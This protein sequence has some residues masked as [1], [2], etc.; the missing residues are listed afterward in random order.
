MLRVTIELIDAHD[1]KVTELA[2][3]N[4]ENIGENTVC[5]YRV[6]GHDLGRP[7]D[8]LTFN[9]L[10]SDGWGKLLK[11]VLYIALETYRS[12]GKPHA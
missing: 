9:H 1:N 4:I 12:F 5:D 10:R 11:R 2:V 7:I 6:T 8:L 3:M